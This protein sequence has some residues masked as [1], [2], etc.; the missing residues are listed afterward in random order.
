MFERCYL[1]NQIFMSSNIASNSFPAVLSSEEEKIYLDKFKNGNTEAKDIL[2]KKN[3]RLVAH[4]VK[5]YNNKESED[6][7]SIGTIG[8]IK[9]INTFNVYKS[10][11]IAPYAARCIDNEILMYIRTS[12]K[13][14][15]DFSIYQKTYINDTMNKI[16]LEDKLTDIKENVSD[17]VN[18]KFESTRVREIIRLYLEQR[19]KLIIVLRYGLMDGCEK[20]QYEI[21]KMLGISRSY[22]SRIEKRAL[23]K[24]KSRMLV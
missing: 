1:L 14:Y 3:L 6:L 17:K 24:I 21:A 11:R 4:I 23:K 8:L 12:K 2:I 7:I 20:T 9:A 13:H 5:K 18:L 16:G 22:V 10:T 19:E 15:N